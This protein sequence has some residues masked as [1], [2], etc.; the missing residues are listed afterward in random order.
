MIPRRVA[1]RTARRTSRRVG[2]RQ[3]MFRDEEQGSQESATEEIERLYRLKEEGA[4][5]EAE[6]EKRKSELI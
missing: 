5:T 6:Y 2:R 4:I 1:R 3:E